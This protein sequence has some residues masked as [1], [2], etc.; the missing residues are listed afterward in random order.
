MLVALITGVS[1][2][3]GQLLAELLINKNYSVFGMINGQRIENTD[4]LVSRLPRL[5]LVSGDL[6]DI[7]SL[8][9]V[10]QET[11]PDE[12]YNLGAISFVGMSFAQPELTANITGMGVL[13]LLEAVRISGL[14]NK[15]R[16]YQA[17]S[18]EQFGKV[19]QVPQTEIT[20]FYP[21]SPYGVA[22]AFA[23]NISV[24]YREAYGMHI[25][26]GILF[27]H[28]SE[29][30]GYEFVTRKISSTV[31][32][33]SLGLDKE[34]RLGDLSP[35]RDWGYARD[36]VN[37]MWLMLQ[38]DIPD[39]YVIATG[40]THTVREFLDLA[41]DIVGMKGHADDYLRIDERFIRP[42]EVNLLIGNPEK[43]NK[44]LGW[45]SQVSFRQLVERMVVNDLAIEKQ[46]IIK[47]S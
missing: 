34:I 44:V 6:A 37:A 36:Y 11:Q 14:G 13:R 5:K 21:R 23:H 10:L 45:R 46:K 4:C 30:R 19:Q 22:K 31:A 47:S 43:A 24:N 33:I 27:N 17:S 7:S 38:Q 40:E 35:Q 9:R 29:F 25:S 18:S 42:S 16:I 28:E 39:D 15:A 8:I 2:Q 26:C 41:F 20:P 1:G 12:I 32:R 3:D